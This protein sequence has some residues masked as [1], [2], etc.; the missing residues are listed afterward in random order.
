[1]EVSKI[2]PSKSQL[3]NFKPDLLVIVGPTASGKTALAIE[4]AKKFDGEI[5]CADSRT[6]YKHLDIG[7][8]KP[9]PQEQELVPHHL[10]DIVE[11]DQPFTVADFKKLANE[12][13]KEIQ[14]R[15]KLP[16][17][18][19]G[20]GLYID[21]VIFDYQFSKSGSKRDSQNPRHLAKEEP[22]Q[23]SA[24][25]RENTLVIGLQVPRDVLRRRIE[26]RIEQ[27]LEN[28]LISE[29]GKLINSYPGSK[30]LDAP[31]YKA[32]TEYL[33]GRLDLDEAKALFIKNDFQ[34]AKRQMT[35]FK[36]NNSIHWIE[37]RGQAVEI[38]TTFLNKKSD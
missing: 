38:A 33:A 21:S 28:G 31:G 7:T 32:F 24:T 1:M 25:L 30:A 15:G 16:I 8:A 10:L 29:A 17:M 14:M 27:M 9:T 13:I 26:A 35:W 20:S 34:L 22:S 11:P 4:L 23:K 12:K 19:G 36:R 18:V 2:P 5:I 37:N 3:S 6:V